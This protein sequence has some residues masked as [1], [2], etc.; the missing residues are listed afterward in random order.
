MRI[1]PL[2]SDEPVA[3]S[4]SCFCHQALYWRCWH[5]TPTPNLPPRAPKTRDLE[6]RS[7]LP[8]EL[9]PRLVLQETLLVVRAAR[10]PN[11]LLMTAVPA[12]PQARTGPRIRDTCRRICGSSRRRSGRLC[13]RSRRPSGVLLMLPGGLAVAILVATDP[14]QAMP[15]ARVHA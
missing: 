2:L 13:R 10:I 6:R 9:G 1:L 7:V 3:N 15:C 11:V 12:V 4:G 5:P 8:L 14:H